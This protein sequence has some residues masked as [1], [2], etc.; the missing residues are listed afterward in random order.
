MSLLVKVKLEQEWMITIV[1]VVEAE[2]QHEDEDDDGGG[3]HKK[4]EK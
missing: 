3:A 4:V 1:Q 2:P